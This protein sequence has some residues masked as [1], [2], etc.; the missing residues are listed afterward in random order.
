MNPYFEML[1]QM[2]VS[3]DPCEW[4]PDMVESVSPVLPNKPHHYTASGRAVF[5][6]E[7]LSWA[8]PDDF[9]FFDEYEVIEEEHSSHPLALNWVDERNLIKRRPVHRYSREERFKFTLAQ[10]MG[11]SGDVP[12][13]VLAAMPKSLYALDQD[14][15]WEEVRRI[16]KQH[17]W[18]LYYNRIPA[19]LARLHLVPRSPSSTCTFQR[20][21]EDFHRMHRVFSEIKQR[22][23]RIYFPNLRYVAVRLMER[24]RIRLP[25]TIP[26][27]RTFKKQ[28]SLDTIYDT[29]W[30]FII[31]QDAQ[32]VEDF[33][34]EQVPT[35]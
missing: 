26:K 1:S 24:H 29:I 18:R 27:T 12:D 31:D 9:G 22:L 19:I 33:F 3:I 15:L 11:C 34:T 20:I 17:G 30:T 14:H 32:D 23:G 2:G 28:E 8:R 25:F 4:E 7:Q 16:L 5:T 21:M 6:S 35:Q 13:H 10:L